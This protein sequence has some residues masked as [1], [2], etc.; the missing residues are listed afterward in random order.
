MILLLHIITALTSLALTSYTLIRPSKLKLNVSYGLV[1]LTLASGTY[2]VIATHSN[3]T[4]SCLAGLIYTSIV[5]GET[6][7][8]KHK[9][10][11]NNSDTVI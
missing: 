8:A 3:L 7:I 11:R 6:S 10:R 5:L 4:P 1:S 9:L 2:L